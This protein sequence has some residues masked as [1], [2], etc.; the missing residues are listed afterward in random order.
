[1]YTYLLPVTWT[2]AASYDDRHEWCYKD[3]NTPKLTM[4]KLSEK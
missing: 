2:A 4:Y 1:M 3:V